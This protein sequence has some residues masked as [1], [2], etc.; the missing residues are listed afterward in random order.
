VHVVGVMLRTGNWLVPDLGG[1]PR[2]QKPPLYYWAAATVSKQMGHMTPWTLRA[3]SAAAALGLAALVF[4]WG[5]A[6]AGPGLGLL[7]AALLAAMLQFLSSARRGDAEMLLAFLATGALFAFDRLDA[8]RRRA[9]LPAFAGL[10]GLAI[11]TK[12]TAV[13]FS[14]ALPILVYLWLRRELRVLR[15]PGVIASCA[16]ALALGLSWYVAILIF[17]PGA[18]E[19]LS[20]ALILPMGGKGSRGDSTHFRAPWWYLT[21]LPVRA[22]PASLALPFVIWRLWRTRV[23][24]DDPRMRFAAL[25]FLVPFA[26]FSLLPQKQKHYTLAML[27]GLALCSAEALCAAARELRPRLAL[28]VRALGPPLAL[29][30]LAGAVLFAL[31]YRWVEGS[32]LAGLLVW[33]GVPI[34]L[35]AGALAGALL[36]RPASFGAGIFVGLLLVLASYRAIAPQIAA[37]PENYTTLSLDERERLADVGRDHAWFVRLLLNA[38]NFDDNDD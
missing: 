19:T 21:V 33:S 6:I 16:G 36:A 25:C 24:R 8:R 38:P 17:V 31:F 9:L 13:V 22:A 30:G 14:V 18:F 12:A 29:A 11:L 34:L 26:A 2:L 32:S 3:V 27:P 20:H 1:K 5:R 7:S 23:Y 10:A 28:F 15:D 4:A 35:L 37:I